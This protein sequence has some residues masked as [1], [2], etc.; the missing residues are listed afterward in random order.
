VPPPAGSAANAVAWYSD[1]DANSRAPV[2]PFSSTDGG[3]GAAADFVC[4]R[5]YK[6]GA[7]AARVAAGDAVTLR[8]S[9]IAADHRG[10]II[11]YLARCPDNRPCHA[12]L[13]SAASTLD[14][15][16][17]RWVKI[18]ELGLVTPAG[19]NATSTGVNSTI[20][21]PHNNQG[22][23]G[24][25]VNHPPSTGLWATDLLLRTN[26]TGLRHDAGEKK[27]ASTTHVAWKV[28]IPVSVPPGYY[29]LR[30]EIIALMG[31]ADANQHYPRCVNLE[32]VAAGSSGNVTAA[33]A[34]WDDAGM[35]N[36]ALPASQ[37]Y[38]AT[39][40]SLAV[41]PWQGVQ[42]YFV[43][44]PPCWK[45]SHNGIVSTTTTPSTTPLAAY[46]TTQLSNTLMTSSTAGSSP[47]ST[48]SMFTSITRTDLSGYASAASSSLD[49]S[50]SSPSPS[51]SVQDAQGQTPSSA[52][53]TDEPT[54]TIRRTIKLTTTRTTTAA[55]LT[56]DDTSSSASPTPSSSVAPGGE[57]YS[58]RE[59]EGERVTRSISSVG[60][61]SST[62]TSTPSTSL[63]SMFAALT[64]TDLTTPAAQPSTSTVTE[65]MTP[66]LSAY[67]SATGQL[68]METPASSQTCPA[69][70]T[71]TVTPTVT[72]TPTVT[73]T[74]VP[75][76]SSFSFSVGRFSPPNPTLPP[77][78]SSL[79][80]ALSR[81]NLSHRRYPLTGLA[82]AQLFPPSVF[83]FCAIIPAKRCDVFE[84]THTDLT[85]FPR[86]IDNAVHNRRDGDFSSSRQRHRFRRQCHRRRSCQ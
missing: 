18:A 47:T 3:G 23:G 51:T 27:E 12:T 48:P 31:K 50:S 6:P 7:A 43:P 34:P 58:E 80:I 28:T 72:L 37:L 65:T 16:Q 63:P 39:D 26:L 22:G 46:G 11:D 49:Q 41:G 70:V 33:A 10:P 2:N 53:T 17:L 85:L 64:R 61:S 69:P 86:C 9:S 56:I 4:G 82:Y 81:F 8:W 57:R 21:G 74:V 79:R 35:A 54:T 78:S 32:I 19:A 30:E 20:S 84:L 60:S 83:V 24:V 76:V 62:T 75:E 67:S 42:Q 55:T 40:P 77:K 5:H 38:S 1:D 52:A 14:A 73:V 66:S 71:V 29:V 44:G 25:N 59:A 15:T 13:G 45:P 68:T 36:G